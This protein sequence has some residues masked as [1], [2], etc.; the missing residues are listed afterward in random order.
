[1][2]NTLCPYSWVMANY[3]ITG[4]AGFIGSHLA[5]KLLKMGH[6]VEIIDDLS[7]GRIENIPP[8]AVFHK[9]DLQI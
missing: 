7:K 6:S 8:G 4:G 5:K 9:F 2:D 1:M 3:L